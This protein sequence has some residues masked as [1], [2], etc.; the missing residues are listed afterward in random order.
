MR[1]ATTDSPVNA[2]INSLRVLRL[3]VSAALCAVLVVEVVAPGAS[4]AWSL[5]V[6]AGTAAVVAGLKALHVIT[7]V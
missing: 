1:P 5:G 4:E 7:P 3:L 6:G 2:M